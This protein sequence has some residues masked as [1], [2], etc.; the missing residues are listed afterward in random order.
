MNK[1]NVANLFKGAKMF[2]SKHS[3]EI[4]TGV[5]IAGMVVSTILA[6]KATPKALQ[7]IE[8]EKYE[9]G[10]DKLTPVD[11]VKTTWKCYVPT[12]VTAATSIGCLIGA[13][14][15]N[16]R[17]NAALAT[18]YKLSETAFVE[19][20]EQVLDTLG[21][22]KEKQV[23][24]KVDKARLEKHPVANNEVIVTKTGTTMCFDPLSGRHFK[25]SIEKI[26]RAENKLNKQLI[27]DIS[28]YVSLNEFYD[29]LG[30]DHTKV[31]DDLGWNTEN[32]LDIDFSSQINDQ[33][34]PEI[35]IDYLTPPK[36]NFYY[37]GC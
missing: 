34:E 15:V 29:E 35:V 1:S 27:H 6:V 23:R 16:L 22:K 4:L 3:P 19:Y 13:N 7:L 25:S 17:R 21:E 24:E 30:L 11:V 31:G 10:V 36:Y 20:K 8:E 26:Q 9:Q 14:S 32:Q 18:A 5:G 37:I 33:N 2:V 12:A 28:G